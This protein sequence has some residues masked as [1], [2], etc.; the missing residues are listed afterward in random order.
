MQ[1]PNAHGPAGGLPFQVLADRDAARGDRSRHHRPMPGHRERPVDG[2]PEE[3]RIL[4]DRDARAEPLQLVLQRVDAQPGHGRGPHDGRP[5]EERAPDQLADLVLDQADP[6]RL[7]QVALGQD[8]QAAREPKQPE[9][10]EVLARLG[11]HRVVRRDDEH[12]QVQPR[13]PRQHVAD[14]SLV[15]RHVDQGKVVGPQRE[16]CEPQVDGDPALLLGGQPVGIHPRQGADQ[17][18]LAVV[19]MPRRPQHQ[20]TL[21]ASPSIASPRSLDLT[22]SGSC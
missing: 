18:R 9:D 16:R 19:D 10:L 15:P 17:R 12:G 7:G 21:T 3:A 6:R 13:R 2:H 22:A 5:L 4:P 20:V 11:H 8:D 1:A 14:E